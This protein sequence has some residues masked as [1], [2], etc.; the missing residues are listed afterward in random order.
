MWKS[1]EVGINPAP[2][3][4]HIVNQSAL[5]AL[6]QTQWPVNKHWTR[7]KKKL[8]RNLHPRVQLKTYSNPNEMMM[9]IIIQN[10]LRFSFQ[11]LRACIIFSTAS[12]IY[13]SWTGKKKFLPPLKFGRHNSPRSRDWMK[14][15]KFYCFS[16]LILV[17]L[18]GW[19]QSSW[20]ILH[21]QSFPA[22]DGKL[23]KF[24]FFFFFALSW[25]FRQPLSAFGFNFL[26]FVIHR[27]LKIKISL[28]F[29]SNFQHLMLLLLLWIISK[30]VEKFHRHWIKWKTFRRHD[31]W[32]NWK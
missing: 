31:E 28:T 2:S 18:L 11:F 7:W 9:M 30:K 29:S 10:F 20:Q 21:H 14:H 5:D 4:Y 15:V 16:L 6:K 26:S 25:H 12:E 23:E 13:D 24:F 3:T 1:E 8:S 27:K 22:F 17:L 19:L 32:E